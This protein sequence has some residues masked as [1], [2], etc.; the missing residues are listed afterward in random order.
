MKL[1]FCLLINVEVFYKLIV[2]LWAFIVRHAQ[3]TKNNKSVISLQ[4]M[5]KNVKDEVDFLPAD[6]HQIIFQIDSIV[7]GVCVKTCP[8]YP[9]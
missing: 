5:K 6:K 4:C 1:I 3:S 8:N 7:L 2:S 9:K